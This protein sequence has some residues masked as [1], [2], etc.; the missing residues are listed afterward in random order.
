MERWERYVPTFGWVFLCLDRST[1][2]DAA[3]GLTAPPAVFD[4]FWIQQIKQGSITEKSY[5]PNGLTAD[6]YRQIRSKDAAK[7]SANYD[8]NVKKAFKFLD[9][10]AFYKARGTDTN[11]A[12]YKSPT[13]GHTMAKTKYDM[14]TNKFGKKYDGAK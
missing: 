1:T 8:K 6:Q 3:V 14:D 12:W 7:A 9:Y 13:R 10:T 2:L 5:V 11:D 4:Y